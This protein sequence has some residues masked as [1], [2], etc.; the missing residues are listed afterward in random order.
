MSDQQL[1]DNLQNEIKN[2]IQDQIVLD[3]DLKG[4]RVDKQV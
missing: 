2:L 1:Y 3:V 4:L